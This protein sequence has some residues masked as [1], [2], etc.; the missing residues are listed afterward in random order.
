LRREKKVINNLVGK[1]A[2][3]NTNK[4]PENRPNNANEANAPNIPAPATLVM[5]TLSEK[6]FN[7][8]S[9]N[10]DIPVLQFHHETTG[11]I[12]HSGSLIG[13]ATLKNTL[14][15]KVKNFGT[16]DFGF[17]IQYP[18]CKARLF[19]EEIKPYVPDE[20]YNEYKKKFN[21]KFKN[22][23]GG[24]KVNFFGEASNAKCV[25]KGGRRNTRKTRK[26]RITRR[27]ISKKSKKSRRHT[28]KYLS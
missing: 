10:D 21:R 11:G 25:V 15:E 17:C 16:E 22:T 12:D 13:V 27:K 14:I 18:D 2:W 6:G 5:P 19:P 20:L 24:A 23:S 28:V 1:K 4:F 3:T 8:I 7:S 9:M 26:A